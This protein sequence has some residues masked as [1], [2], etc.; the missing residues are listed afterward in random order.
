[1]KLKPPETATGT[2]V[3][4]VAPLPSS[5]LPLKPQQYAAPAVVSAQLWRAPAEIAP[6]FRAPATAT[7]NELLVFDPLPNCPE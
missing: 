2:L 1:V 4:S 3:E 5:P 7:G 6:K